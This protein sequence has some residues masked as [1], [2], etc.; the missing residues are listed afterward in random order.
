[1]LKVFIQFIVSGGLLLAGCS[2]DDHSRSI[3]RLISTVESA[4]TAVGD[5]LT[6]HC[7]SAG[8]FFDCTAANADFSITIPFVKRYSAGVPS[9]A[10]KGSVRVNVP[11]YNC[12]NN[13]THTQKGYKEYRAQYITVTKRYEK[14][15]ES[16]KKEY[17]TD[18]TVLWSSVVSRSKD[19]IYE[20]ERS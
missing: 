1:M 6:I 7:G 12:G 11:S 8:G 5:G 3:T 9:T 13:K 18:S 19:C 10:Q 16:G 15:Y 17:S 14:I 2:N 20:P 4:P